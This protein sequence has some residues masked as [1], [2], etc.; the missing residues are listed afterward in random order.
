M[1]QG[2]G[3]SALLKFNPRPQIAMEGGERIRRILLACF[4]SCAGGI[5]TSRQLAGT[6]MDGGRLSAFYPLL[7]AGGAAFCM[8]M[9]I[10]FFCGKEPLGRWK[11]GF[12]FLQTGLIGVRSLVWGFFAALCFL[13]GLY[14]CSDAMKGLYLTEETKAQRSLETLDG[15][16][17]Q[18]EGILRQVTQNKEV[19]Q[20]LLEA[21]SFRSPVKG[22]L[23]TGMYIRCEEAEEIV[24][25]LQPGQRI[26]F[27]GTFSLFPRASNPGSFDY[28]E[29][30][31][32]L[33]IGGQ[34]QAEA[35]TLHSSGKGNR[36]LFAIW[37]LGR[38]LR[39]SILSLASEE[40]RGILLCL[41]TG[42]RSE[43]D[44]DWKTL[45]QEGGIMHLLSLSGLHISL[46]GMGVC[47]L[48]RRWWGHF[49]GSC[50]LSAGLVCGFCV[51]AGEGTSLMR[52]TLC[53]L[54]YLVAACVG[55]TYDMVTAAAAAGLFLLLIHPLL[56]F[57]AGF[58]MTFCCV[59][60]I[61][62]VL[63]VVI[64]LFAQEIPEGETWDIDSKGRSG[65]GGSAF[66]TAKKGLLSA[67]WLQIFSLPA[68]L[69]FQGKA[70]LFGAWVNL[71]TV[72]LIGLVLLSA[73]LAVSAAFFWRPA[74]IFLLGAAHYILRWY[75]KVCRV[76]SSMAISRFTGGR[77]GGWQILFWFCFLTGG[78][79]FLYRRL[80]DRKKK[81]PY[82]LG[83]LAFPLSLLLLHRIPSNQLCIRFLDV[84]QGDGIV[85]ELPAGKGVFCV[86]GGSSSQ[87]KLE[88]YVYLP[89][90]A[91]EGIDEVEGWLITHPDLDHYSAAVALL[92]AGFPVR[93]VY[94]PAV[95]QNT[96]L[97]QRL[98]A[99]H[100]IEYLEAGQ[101]LSVG[102]MELQILSPA[103]QMPVADTNEG[104]AVACLQWGDF[105]A[106]LTADMG[107]GEEKQVLQA[108]G[109]QRALLL[110][111]AHHGSRSSTGEAFLRAVRPVFS[112]ISCGENNRY[113]HP[114]PE[115]LQRLEAIGSRIY[116]TR[117]DGAI[118][119]YTDGKSVRIHSWLSDV[120]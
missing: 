41:L 21:V 57:Q 61:G 72:P 82:L 115:V 94:L 104:S 120:A 44:S 60:G 35:G 24:R 19:Y 55:K 64:L 49:G 109:G 110:K 33:G 117:K 31:L 16:E 99:V 90:F 15:R 48:L 47:S 8:G 54:L 88:E 20:L 53:F 114:H 87:K 107:S 52:A 106:L 38:E 18:G 91:Y 26:S 96:E 89:Y 1:E 36:V 80:C 75:E 30:C 81:A 43:L 84:G 25:A 116:Q 17:V 10:L 69:W 58:L 32:S 34:I 2:T 79:W 101:I 22:R 29:Y 37:N 14:G 5:F 39:R 59:F 119:V 100:A 40:D 86:D 118:T 9:T 27:Q 4:L 11:E 77:P 13:L 7:A 76:F 23:H 68:V 78:L 97:A 98:E 62:L 83:L 3:G 112:I 111:V 51:M 73:F 28:R 108:M 93:H 67:V 45:Y 63:S 65:K 42:D 71:L 6:S 12:S 105:S 95:F 103:G 50:V 56:L 92:E 102:K 113:G 74:G 70:P 85:L 46:L 66:Q